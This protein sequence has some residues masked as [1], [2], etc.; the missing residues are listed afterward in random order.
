MVDNLISE[1]YIEIRPVEV[2]WMRLLD[3]E[4]FS[5]RRVFEPWEILEGHEHFLVVGQKPH[6]VAGNVSYFN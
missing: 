3:M 2:V 4:D 6:P 1:V 5:H